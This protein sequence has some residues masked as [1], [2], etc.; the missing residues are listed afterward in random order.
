MDM[1]LS[2]NVRTAIFTDMAP[3]APKVVAKSET[4]VQRQR[5]YAGGSYVQPQFTASEPQLV[6]VNTVP[7][8]VSH[9]HTNGSFT[10][11]SRT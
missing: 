1:A 3:N 2:A 9:L 10:V 6:N 4:S 11:A 5:V 8:P 7:F